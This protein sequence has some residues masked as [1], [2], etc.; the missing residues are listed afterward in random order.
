MRRLALVVAC[1]AAGASLLG[2]QAGTGP[3]RVTVVTLRDGSRLLGT[4]VRADA[5]SVVLEGALGRLA[6]PR[7]NVARVRTLPP[8][9]SDGG[10]FSFPSHSSRLVFGPTARVQPLGDAYVANHMLFLFDGSAG[11]GHNVS[12]GGG[13]TLI[14]GLD[15]RDNLFY[16][17]PKIGLVQSD[18]LNVAAGAVVGGVA[19]KHESAISFGIAYAVASFGPPTK[20][21]SFG[22]GWGYV[23]GSWANRP[24]LMLGGELR[25]LDRL[26]FVSENYTVPDTDAPLITFVARVYGERMSGDL[27]LGFVGGDVSAVYPVLG[28]A[29]RF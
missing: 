5:D 23:N 2:A 3:A 17:L 28:L 21:V 25:V 8:G 14:P 1:L 9:E 10:R 13:V 22:A 4:L 27:G 24:A 16:A 29:I 20:S 6:F 12:I 26:A 7:V 11:I 15:L 18:R 19:P